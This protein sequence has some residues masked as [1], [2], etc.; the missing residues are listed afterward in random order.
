MSALE[1]AMKMSLFGRRAVTRSSRMRLLALTVAFICLTSLQLLSQEATV[2]G[3]VTDQTGAALPNVTIT[4]TNSETGLTRT[5]K[6]N[7]AGEYVVPDLHIGPY[8]AKAEATGFNE[9][10]RTGI[11][12]TVGAR[13]RV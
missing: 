7:D 3:T 1:N 5:I 6:S 13:L 12:L 8:T 4:L 10:E 9:S 2:V 11:V